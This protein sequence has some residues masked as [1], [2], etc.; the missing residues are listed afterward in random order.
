MV[1]WKES[2]RCQRM[3]DEI[4][5]CE[6][7]QKDHTAGAQHA[8][9]NSEIPLPSGSR[10]RPYMHR[11]D[12]DIGI[13]GVR[14]REREGERPSCHRTQTPAPV[15][16]DRDETTPMVVAATEAGREKRSWFD[17]WNRSQFVMK[18]ERNWTPWS[19]RVGAPSEYN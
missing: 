11:L 5:Y 15:G 4:L 2:V 19:W 14:E 18:G 9:G 6:Q 3:G 1:R 12:E 16:Q 7:E 13:S 10:R 17:R 8:R